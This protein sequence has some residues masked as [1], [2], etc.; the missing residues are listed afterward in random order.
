[1]RSWTTDEEDAAAASGFDTDTAVEAFIFDYLG[2]IYAAV[3]DVAGN[4]GLDFD[5]GAD[6]AVRLALL[7]AE[8][9]M[10]ETKFI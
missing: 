1:V 3:E 2:A 7:S 5:D 8:T 10:S 4:P 9:I 6:L